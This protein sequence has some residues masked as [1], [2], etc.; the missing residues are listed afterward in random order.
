ML[1]LRNRGTYRFNDAA[2]SIYRGLRFI[3]DRTLNGYALYRPEEWDAPRSDPR[4]VVDA[5]GRIRCRGAWTGYTV[6][7]LV[8]IGEAGSGQADAHWPV[9]QVARRPVHRAHE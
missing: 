4:F 5:H 2:A 7:E 6:E 8:P 3:A 1:Y 9:G